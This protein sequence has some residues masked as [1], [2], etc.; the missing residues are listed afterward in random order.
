MT[1]MSGYSLHANL[2]EFFRTI[3]DIPCAI[4]TEE[5]ATTLVT[6]ATLISFTKGTEH[7]LC[8]AE[9]HTS[10]ITGPACYIANWYKEDT[11]NIFKHTTGAVL[12][13]IVLAI[14]FRDDKKKPCQ[15]CQKENK[16]SQKKKENNR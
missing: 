13:T 14:I 1:G 3:W 15:T 10:L 12:G 7:F 5:I 2:G 9:D 11:K 4:L 16:D 8:Y 6:F